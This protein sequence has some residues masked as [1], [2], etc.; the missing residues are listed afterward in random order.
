MA[1]TKQTTIVST[2]AARASAAKLAGAKIPSAAAAASRASGA[3]KPVAAAA[4]TKTPIVAAEGAIAKKKRRVRPGTKAEREIRRLQRGTELLIPKA[5]IH[6][7]IREIIEAH[8]DERHL[9]NDAPLKVQAKA[10]EALQEATEDVVIR[11]L[12]QTRAAM[13]HAKRV[14]IMR[15]DIRFAAQNMGLTKRTVVQ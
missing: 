2:T 4:A 13:H 9:N 7:L 12:G 5:C 15:R 14:T 10:L 3:K 6:R 1:R 8:R 11:L